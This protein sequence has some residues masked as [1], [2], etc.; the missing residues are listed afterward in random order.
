[1][2]GN[3][4]N[5]T[6]YRTAS[7]LMAAVLVLSLALYV[8]SEHILRHAMTKPIKRE[9][10]DF[11]K[12]LDWLPAKTKKELEYRARYLDLKQK[13]ETAQ[14]EPE[15][16]EAA[17]NF[18]VHTRDI[19][20][21]N[22]ALL[23]YVRHPEK[24]SSIP[25]LHR[26][27]VQ[28]LYDPKN[29]QA[30]SIQ[31]YYDYMNSRKDP[32]EIF[33][34]WNDGRN[35]LQKVAGKN[36]ALVTIEFLK[37]L[38]DK[39][40]DYFIIKDYT[41]CLAALRSNARSLS[42]Q[43]S[44]RIANKSPLPD[45]AETAAS[46][47]KLSLAAENLQKKITSNPYCYTRGEY[48]RKEKARLDYE[49]LKPEQNPIT[50]GFNYARWIKNPAERKALIRN[51]F[52]NGFGKMTPAGLRLYALQADQIGVKGGVVSAEEYLSL[53]NS[54]KTPVDIFLFWRESL[55][56]LNAVRARSAA[57]LQLLAP[58]MEKKAEDLPFRDYAAFY[59]QIARSAV[60]LNQPELLEKATEMK[61]NIWKL[62]KISFQQFQ[63]KK[64]GNQIK[65]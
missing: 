38:L 5:T 55:N 59:D 31:Q 46:M 50:A 49:N 41:G 63:K 54:L 26:A 48:Q 62:N 56:R 60:Y 6:R 34:I 2:S 30:I 40:F 44:R 36:R 61:K 11:G 64:S 10:V 12:A 37:P 52:K 47:M 45:D 35:R 21:H 28:M 24:Y 14:K 27:F 17:Y 25:N 1:M 58:L 15:K 19:K 8:V 57:K 20:E 29:P 32:L 39:P 13:Y 3:G 7:I 65:K 9:K 53:L 43:A 42:L 51:I 22:E 16:F 33:T 23:P 18:A 4:K